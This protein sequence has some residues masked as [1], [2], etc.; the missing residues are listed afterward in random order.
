M[1]LVRFSYDILPMN[2][3]AAIG[4]IQQE[5]EAARQNGLEARLL[6]PL[7]RGFGG[8]AL[9]F[10]V[11]MDNL[12]GSTASAAGAS[13]QGR[14][15]ATGCMRSARSCSPRPWSR[16]CGCRPEIH[17]EIGSAGAGSCWRDR[18]I[19]L[20]PSGVLA[21]VGRNARLG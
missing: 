16:S 21:H 10:K 13:V 11:E 14:R 7:T 19:D 5:V 8:A 20:T 2:R 17:H 6:V 15:Q 4:F 9:Q 1:Y 3:E 12:S 18:H